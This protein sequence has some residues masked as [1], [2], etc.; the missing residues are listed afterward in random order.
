M[1]AG[2]FHLG[3]G[4]CGAGVPASTSCA[5]LPESD[6][7]SSAELCELMNNKS[8]FICPECY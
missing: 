6:L 3:G 7:P 8:L 5:L 2:V 1:E 4:Q